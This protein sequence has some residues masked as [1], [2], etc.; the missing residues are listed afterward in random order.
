LL[1]VV[2][3]ESANLQLMKRLLD[4]D[5]RL[6]FAKDGPRAFDLACSEHPDLILL[7]VMMPGMTGHE[8]C[9]RLKAN[10]GTSSIP[11]IFVTASRSAPSTTSTSRSAPRSCA[12]VYVRICRWCISTSCARAASRSSCV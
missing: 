8:T 4:Q 12:P 9:Q 1:L 10:S 6:L 3:D 11:V 7:D 2:D 5:Y